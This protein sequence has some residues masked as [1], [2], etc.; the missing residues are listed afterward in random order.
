MTLT[1][2]PHGGRGDVEIQV[3]AS[4]GLQRLALL[5]VSLSLSLW[6]LQVFFKGFLL[7]KGFI[8]GIPLRVLSRKNPPA[9][10]EGALEKRAKWLHLAICF[11]V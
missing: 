4:M 8:Y 3:G 2:A 10:Q 7:C 6:V 9:F 1:L 11:W 5:C